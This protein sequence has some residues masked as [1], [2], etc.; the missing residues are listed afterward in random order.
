LQ[1]NIGARSV[2]PVRDSHGVMNLVVLARDRLPFGLSLD[3]LTGRPFRA[4]APLLNERAR[5]RRA[6]P[7]QRPCQ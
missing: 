2:S 1:L 6:Q 4:R 7:A 3:D 5:A